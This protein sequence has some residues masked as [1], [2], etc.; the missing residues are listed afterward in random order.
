MD[1]D[2]LR[3]EIRR[4]APWHHDVEVSPGIRTGDYEASA[5]ESQESDAVSLI[6]PDRAVAAL[7]DDLFPGGLAGRSVLDCA[8]NAGGYLF[9][10]AGVGAGR[11]FG[12]DVRDH[13]I[14]Q[15]RF[16]ARHLPADNLEFATCDLAELPRLGLEP[17]DVT[18]FNGLFYHLPDPVGGLRIA[19]DLTREVIVVNTSGVYGRRE[20]L[21]LT[22]ESRTAPM[23]GVHGLAWH[24]TRHEVL[25]R[26]LSWCGFPHA[27][28]RWARCD[29]R[30][31]FRMEVVAA[32]EAAS[33]A[34][35]DSQP[36]RRLPGTLARTFAW[37][38]GGTRGRR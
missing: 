32:R 10:A 21:V 1:E 30:R 20:G 11:C 19:A 6:R 4:L 29:S 28:L 14:E 27:R 7:V 17:F 31:T 24:P 38:F 33:L 23:S 26:I 16:L 8:C 15:S 3:A 9:A 25:F 2:A 36:R 5:T 22:P 37:L 13:W 34:H 18:L 12:F 35:Y